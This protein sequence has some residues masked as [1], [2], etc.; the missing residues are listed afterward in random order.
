MGSIGN[1]TRPTLESFNA[2]PKIFLHANEE[3]SNQLR[4]QLKEDGKYIC[5]IAWKSKNED[6]GQDKS[7]L[8]ESLLPILNLPNITFVSLQYGDT[9]EEI[10]ALKKVHVINIKTIGEI[11]NF[12]DIDGLASLIN[13]CDF[14]V[15]TSN[16]TAHLAGGLG[17]ETYLLVPF[18]QGRI[19][20]WHEGDTQ[21]IWYP[22]VNI[23]RQPSPDDW[24]QP[25]D[26]ITHIL[27]SKELNERI[28]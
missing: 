26:E 18:A 20:Y 14:V 19:W 25:I 28:H 11:D 8:L 12:N 4:F 24:S 1:F 27:E 7:I 2:Q 22:S 6:F 21:S 5:G 10:A 17:K 9:K 23:Y 15:T 3:L 13:A 16:V